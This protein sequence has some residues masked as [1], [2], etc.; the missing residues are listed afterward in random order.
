[1]LKILGIAVLAIGC[2]LAALIVPMAVT[3]QLNEEILGALF[4][5]EDT[6]ASVNSDEGA[7][8]P[9]ATKLRSE[10]KRLEDWDARLG[11]EDA[12]LTQRERIIDENLTE[13]K[14]I[15]TE[16]VTAMDALDADRQAAIQ[17]I[18]KTMQAMSAQNAATD[19]QAMTPEEAARI[20]PMIKDRNRGKILDEMDA[21][22]RSLIL[23][24]QQ[25]RK[26]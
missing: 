26:Y 18:A 7:L 1:M 11:D 13:L 14:Q 20:L 17:S 6:S 9:L 16:V 10:Q 2:F 25:E 8:G 4:G 22:R 24:V 15:Q 3:G 19:L 5:G 23:Q 12:R 21:D